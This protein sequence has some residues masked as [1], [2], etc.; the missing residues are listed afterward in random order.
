MTCDRDRSM[1]RDRG[2]GLQG[3]RHQAGH[4]PCWRSSLNRVDP[5]AFH[6]ALRISGWL[7]AVTGNH[8]FDALR[9]H[10]GLEVVGQSADIHAS[11]FSPRFRQVIS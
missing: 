3:W 9:P 8:L 4:T 10:R 7:T 2:R 6:M 5:A 11:N 1:P